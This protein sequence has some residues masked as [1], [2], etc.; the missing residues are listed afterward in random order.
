M[1]YDL[2]KRDVSGFNKWAVPVTDAL[3]AQKQHSLTG[4]EA[5]IFEV[6]LAG[7]FRV[8]QQTYEVT[9]MNKKQRLYDFYTSRKWGS[10]YQHM[11]QG[12]FWKR[13]K[14]ILG[15]TASYRR[16]SGGQ[17]EFV[18]NDLNAAREAFAEATQAGIYWDRD[19]D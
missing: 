10:E 6:L 13:L 12:W 19:D 11:D 5:C 1:L 18:I 4:I 14:L 15:D 2:L 17:R 16:S 3:K 8:E 9:N 7:E